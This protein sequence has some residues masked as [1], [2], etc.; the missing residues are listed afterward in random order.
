MDNIT[1]INQDYLSFLKEQEDN[2]FDV[3]YFDPM[4]RHTLTDSKSQIHF[5]N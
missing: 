4:F 1:V 2:S 3:I 5:A